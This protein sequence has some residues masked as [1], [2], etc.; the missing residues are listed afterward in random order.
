MSSGTESFWIPLDAQTS[1]MFSRVFETCAIDWSSSPDLTSLPAW[2]PMWR[3]S[4]RTSRSE[5]LDVVEHLKDAQG[6][7]C[8]SRCVILSS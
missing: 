6:V 8:R 1:H 4:S 5:G 3:N 7:W 2:T